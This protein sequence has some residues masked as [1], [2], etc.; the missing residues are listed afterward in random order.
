MSNLVDNAIRYTAANGHITVRVL[1]HDAPAVQ[2]EDDG[3]GI[4]VAERELVFERFYRVI[5]GNEA[6][7]GIGLAIVR[8]IAVRHGASVIVTTPPG[9]AGTLFTVTFARARSNDM[10]DLAL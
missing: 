10:P 7:S 2:V 1:D 9:G 5:G 8:E 4:P 3:V 6:G